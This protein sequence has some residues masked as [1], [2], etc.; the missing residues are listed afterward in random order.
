MNALKER[1]CAYVD[2][3]ADQLIS[4][5]RDIYNHP[6]LKFEEF[7]ASKLLAE[8]MKKAGF[9]TKLGVAA[10]E[11]AIQADH[12]S[13]SDGPTV[14]I[15]SEYDA[16][17]GIG[18]ACGHNLI[19]AAGLGAALAVGTIKRDLPGKLV[20]LG[21]P[22]EEG[23]G[24]KVVMV[25]AGLFDEVD[26]AMM[27]HPS[28]HTVV[29]R[30]SLAITEVMIEFT[31]KASHA[32]GS[33]EKGINALDA[34]IQT[35]NGINALR[36]HIKD[37]ARI[38]GIITNGGAKPNIVPEHAAAN[39]YVRALEND[40][41]DELLEKLRACAEGAALAT[42]ATLDFKIVGHSYKAMKPNSVIGDA[43]VKNLAQLG[44]PLNPPP[45]DAGM[46]S[47]DMGD[48]SQVVPSIHAYI[49]ICDENVAGHSREF[50]EASISQRGLDV[51]IIAAKAMAMTAIDILTNPELAKSMWE[52]FRSS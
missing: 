3:I 12:P 50:A 34:V 33:P 52:E 32:A 16:L 46:G 5:S 45:P 14:A 9:A 36:Q 48:V 21:T 1:A 35:F 17:P 49:E 37:G 27:F 18:H 42:G 23:G 39:F 6:E 13:V 51:M 19:A 11:T 28:S 20:F 8:K 44:E 15:I 40:Y 2:T 41:R 4:V 10:L 24:G 22:G 25:D 30:K 31:G 38:H 47:T 26:A 7:R 43:F 29:D